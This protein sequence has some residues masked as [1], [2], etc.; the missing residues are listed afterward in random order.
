AGE[1]DADG[2][3]AETGR[4]GAEPARPLQG[5]CLG[6]EA[7]GQHH[8]AIERQ[9]RRGIARE[10]RE[11]AG[12][13]TLGIEKLTVSDFERSNRRHG[14]TRPL[15]YMQSVRAWPGANLGSIWACGSIPA[16]Q[17]KFGMRRDAGRLDAA[18]G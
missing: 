13:A 3:L 17:R 9:Q 2:F 14:T 12:W 4:I 8:G 6:I 15:S 16:R 11:G 5:N 10:R 18:L 1:A 7:A